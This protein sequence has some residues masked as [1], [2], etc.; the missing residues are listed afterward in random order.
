MVGYGSISKM[1]VP[2]GTVTAVVGLSL[3]SVGM[4]LMEAPTQVALGM[5][6]LGAGMILLYK[7]LLKEGVLK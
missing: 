4:K 6:T 2:S 3:A 5:P 7:G 1:S